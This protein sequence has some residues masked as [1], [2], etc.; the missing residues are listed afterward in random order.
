M[1]KIK[2]NL[3]LQKNVYVNLVNNQYFIKNLIVLYYWLENHNKLIL[4]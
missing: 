1:N 3:L 2:I 4:N